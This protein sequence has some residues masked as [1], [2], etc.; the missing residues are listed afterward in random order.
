MADNHF[1]GLHGHLKIFFNYLIKEDISAEE[2]IQQWEN[3]SN[4]LVGDHTNCL[5]D[6]N[7]KCY[8]WKDGNSGNNKN[9]LN[10]LLISSAKLL[11][12]CNLNLSTQMCESFHATKSRFANKLL[13]W[14]TS[15]IT[16][17]C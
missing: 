10:L 17:I 3:A 16:R 9:I 2:K 15:W 13:N 14:K 11:V 12:H 1:Y 4:H 6:K 5:H 7:Q 8:N